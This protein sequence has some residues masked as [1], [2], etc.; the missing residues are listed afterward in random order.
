VADSPGSTTSPGPVITTLTPTLT[1]EPITGVTFTGYLIYLYNATTSTTVSYTTGASVNS[2]TI[3]SPLIAGDTYEWNVRGVNGSVT[4][5]ESAYLY[6]Q[7][8]APATLPAPVADAPGSTTSPGPVL[9][10]LTPTFSWEAITGVTFTGYQINL[11]NVTADTTVSYTTGVSVTSYTVPSTAP[12]IAGDTYVWNVRA[13]N[14][15]VSGAATVT[16]PA[17]VADSPGSSTSPGPLVTTLTPTFTWQ[18]ITG[19]TFTG[20]QLN[21]YNQTTSTGASYSVGSGDTSFTIPS[22]SPLVAGDT[23]VWNVRAV[24]GTASGPPSN[25]LYFQ[26]PGL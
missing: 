22:S 19:A 20:Y 5:T 12:L 9:T 21:I 15:T 3:S 23:Y 18:A 25:Y 4:G 7:T 14:G 6:F 10:T 1:W 26:T 8:P 2:Y 16:L 13:L 17:P 11:H 24:N